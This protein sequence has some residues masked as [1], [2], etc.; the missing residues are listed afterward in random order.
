VVDDLAERVAFI[1]ELLLDE[2]QL[3]V[4][5]VGQAQ[6]VL[7]GFLPV[8]LLLFFPSLVAMYSVL[9]FHF[10]DLIQSQ[11]VGRFVNSGPSSD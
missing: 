8:F 2:E 7:T 10:L 3:L 6:G 5:L 1:L 11:V 9:S 4:E